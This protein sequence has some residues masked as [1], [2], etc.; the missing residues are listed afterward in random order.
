MLFKYPFK[1]EELIHFQ[2]TYF[3]IVIPDI[4]HGGDEENGNKDVEYYWNK[5][6]H[7]PDLIFRILK[8]KP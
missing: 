8:W 5:I 4:S 6:D 3:S 1:E 7:W 2:N